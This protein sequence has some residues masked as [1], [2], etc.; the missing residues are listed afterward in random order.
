M[1]KPHEGPWRRPSC[2]LGSIC[3]ARGSMKAKAAGGESKGEIGI[4]G[5]RQAVPRSSGD[6]GT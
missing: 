4:K 6:S 5:L 1:S 2:A 3:R